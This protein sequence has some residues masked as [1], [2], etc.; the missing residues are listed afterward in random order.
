MNAANKMAI[1]VRNFIERTLDGFS[2]DLFW[3][4]NLRYELS[5]VC[6][7]CLESTGGLHGLMSCSEDDSLHLLR[8]RPGEELICQKNSG[9]ETVSPGWQMWFEVPHTQ[10]ST[11]SFLGQSVGMMNWNSVCLC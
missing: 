9:D 6:T 10:V 1:E 11:I 7:Y 2:R 8:V 5:V 4:S 3:L